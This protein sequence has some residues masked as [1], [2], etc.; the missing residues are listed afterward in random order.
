MS[1]FLAVL[2]IFAGFIKRNSKIVA[3]L[4]FALL[5]VLFGW[6]TDNADYANYER[7]YSSAHGAFRFNSEVGFQLL[8]KLF[9]LAGLEYKHFLIILSFIGLLIIYKTIKI[10]TENIAIV[11]ALYLIFPFI[12]DVVQFRNF[13]IMSIVL[14]GT[15]F[16]I[17]EKRRGTLIFVILVLFATSIHYSALFYLFF[18]L[19]RQKNISSLTILS[20]II[21][22][23]GLIT[24]FTDLIPNL[25]MIFVPSEKIDH[26]FSNRFNWGIIIAVVI[27]AINYF[28]IHYAYLKIRSETESKRQERDNNSQNTNFKFVEAVYKINIILLMLFPLLVFNMIFFRL[29]RNIFILNFIVYSICLVNME[30]K[31][32]E[33]ALFG[34]SVVLYTVSLSVYYIVYS[35]YDTVFLP[36]FQNNS[37]IGQ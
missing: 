33:K 23:F 27:Y 16:I 5:W 2:L 22:V 6:N 32:K 12:I 35:Y 14:Y 7:G 13:L 30:S 37:L 24:V 10:Y 34:F 28:F 19:I 36:V 8:Y 20:L 17:E 1:Y 11:L 31:S 25:A 3:F 29:D 18:I 9:I 21:T 15:H 4:L 26:W